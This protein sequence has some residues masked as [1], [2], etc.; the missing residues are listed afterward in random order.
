[1]GGPARGETAQNPGSARRASEGD[2]QNKAV[3]KNAVKTW[4]QKGEHRKGVR[5]EATAKQQ[6]NS[7]R[8]FWV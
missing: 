2:R 8:A 3:R 4:R 6:V 1:M 5:P 7:V